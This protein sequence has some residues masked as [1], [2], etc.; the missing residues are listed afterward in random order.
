MLHNYDMEANTL[1]TI[2]NYAYERNISSKG[3]VTQF[4]QE[5]SREDFYNS[6][7]Q[8]LYDII[9]D[10]HNRGIE[11]NKANVSIEILKKDIDKEEALNILQIELP[12][13]EEVF[14]H[15]IPRLAELSKRRKM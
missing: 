14:L 5:L 9:E 2:V 3:L 12:T 7:T 10:L 8:K 15:C 13:I 1:G 4:L 11:I 6:T